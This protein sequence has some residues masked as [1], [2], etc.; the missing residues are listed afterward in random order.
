MFTAGQK[1]YAL[2]ILNILDPKREIVSNLLHRDHCVEVEFFMGGK[3]HKEFLKDLDVLDD[4]NPDKTIIV[5]NKLISFGK[6]LENGIPIYP[7]YGNKFDTELLGLIEFLE[8]I[9]DKGGDLR[10]HI[11]ERYC[12]KRLFSG[13]S[14]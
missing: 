11:K 2:A 12:Y 13:V 4:F 5:D 9:V 1:D 10:K 3:L 7:F 6:H 14:S 8:D